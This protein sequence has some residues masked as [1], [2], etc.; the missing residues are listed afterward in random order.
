MSSTEIG[1]TIDS[2]ITIIIG[3]YA[4]LIGLGAVHKNNL[5]FNN[6][7]QDKRNLIKAIGIFLILYG[8]VKI[9]VKI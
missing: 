5:E 7:I 1:F 4:L 9:F 3:I 2:L 8:I 6:K